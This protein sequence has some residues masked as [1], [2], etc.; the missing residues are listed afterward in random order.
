MKIQ[1]APD[2]TIARRNVCGHA[3]VRTWPVLIGPC[4]CGAPFLPVVRASAGCSSPVSAGSD[5]RGRWVIIG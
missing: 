5:Q 2:I 1:K 3:H 4:D